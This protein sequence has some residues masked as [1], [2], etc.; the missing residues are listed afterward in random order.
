VDLTLHI[1][2]LGWE[3]W[4]NTWLQIA[5][6]IALNG[7]STV[8]CGTLTPGQLA[9][10]PARGLIGPIHFCLLD[11]P[12]DVIASRLRDRPPW[13]GSTEKFIHAQQAFAIELRAQ[14]NPQF[15]TSILDIG[16]T[17][18]AIASW[19]NPLLDP[20]SPSHN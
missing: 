6:A 4:R 20:P 12:H 16:G 18:A 10:L 1:A 7:R 13:R 8:L 2:A 3:T 5:G 9:D 14:I 15:D 19:I 11:A 17:A